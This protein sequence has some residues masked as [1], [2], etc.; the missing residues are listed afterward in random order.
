[1][2]RTA[3]LLL[4]II[5][6]ASSFFT[7]GAPQPPSSHGGGCIAAERTALLSFKEGITSDPAGLLAS[8]RGQDCSRWRGVNCSNQT[9]HVIRLRLRSPNPDLYG[10]PCEGNSLFAFLGASRAP[11]PQYELLV[12]AK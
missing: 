7:G 9:G 12:R 1:M 5:I 3:S 8:W 10:D 11:G 4:L 6:S 2:H